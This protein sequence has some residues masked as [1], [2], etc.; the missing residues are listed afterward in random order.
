MAFT[1]KVD[2]KRPTPV[3]RLHSLASPN[4]YIMFRMSAGLR[5]GRRVILMWTG[6]PTTLSDLMQD[7]SHRLTR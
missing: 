1:R 2:L 7:S 6:S 3:T 5:S 4:P